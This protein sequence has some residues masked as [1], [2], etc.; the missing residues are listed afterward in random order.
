MGYFICLI[1]VHLKPVIIKCRLSS[2]ERVRYV[3][4]MIRYSCLLFCFYSLI[5][6]LSPWVTL[7]VYICPFNVTGSFKWTGFG[8]VIFQIRWHLIQKLLKILFCDLAFWAT[9]SS[10][11]CANF[12]ILKVSWWLEKHKYFPLKSCSNLPCGKY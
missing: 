7:F 11:K 10:N 1:S 2:I 6:Q 9:L 3:L 5:F 12:L 4:K 8:R